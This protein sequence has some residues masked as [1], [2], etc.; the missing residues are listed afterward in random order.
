MIESEEF[1]IFVRPQSI[2]IKR[3]MSLLARLS[4][5]NHLTRIQQYFSFMG[6]ISDPIIQEQ[7][8]QITSFKI[9]ATQMNVTLRKF[10][11]HLDLMEGDF[12]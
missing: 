8:S 1:N 9:A 12:E 7:N 6:V 4:P 3:E 5:E 2:N 10:K 11:T